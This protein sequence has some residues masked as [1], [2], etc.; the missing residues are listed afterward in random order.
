MKPYQLI[1]KDLQ[2]NRIIVELQ[3]HSIYLYRNWQY[4]KNLQSIFIESKFD[5]K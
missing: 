2:K 1:G 5:R 4:G 3:V